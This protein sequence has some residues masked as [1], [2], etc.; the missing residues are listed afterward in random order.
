[1]TPT[2]HD[3]SRHPRR[4]TV[5]YFLL[6]F[7]AAG[8]LAVSLWGPAFSKKWNAQKH[9]M[10]VS[11]LEEIL[12]INDLNT[13][14]AVY[15]GVAEVRNEKNPSEIDC[16]V[17]YEAKIYAG[18]DF[19]DIVLIK[20]DN[21]KRILV[22]LPEVEIRDIQVDVG[23]F[24]YIYLNKVSDDVLM[25]SRA[26][27]ASIA[28]VEEESKNEADIYKHAQENAIHVVEALISPFTQQFDPDYDLIIRGMDNEQ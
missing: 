1:M 27:K 15:N 23:A 28:D 25:T 17:S 9:V 20:D 13:Y 14:Q 16:Y 3:K 11:R 8:M 6:F 10:T 18:I 26:Y 5:S 12:E 7:L 4:R 21:L 2:P 24:D 22:T 19:K